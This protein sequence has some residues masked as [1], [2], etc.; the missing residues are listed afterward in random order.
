M[1][2]TG[3]VLTFYGQWRGHGKND[4][5]EEGL[6]A[7][8]MRLPVKGRYLL[9]HERQSRASGDHREKAHYGCR[10]IETGAED[11]VCDGRARARESARST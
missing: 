8:G 9:D 6:V 11:L 10:W 1:A 3:E 7:E 5:M 2:Q 4:V